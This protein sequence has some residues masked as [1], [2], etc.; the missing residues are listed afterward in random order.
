MF[1]RVLILVSLF[2]GG[3]FLV[4]NF[5]QLEKVAFA[6]R[7]G[8]WED[9]AVAVVFVV[10][11]LVNLA[12]VYRAIYR[13]LGVEENL[14]SLFI[15]ATASTFVNIVT[16]GGL[17]GGVALFVNQASVRGYSIAKATLA[18]LLFLVFDLIGFAAVLVIG[19]FVLVRRDDLT[20]AT[21]SASIILFFIAGLLIFLLVLGLQSAEKLGS[22]MGGIARLTNRIL[23]LFLKRDYLS[24]RDAV[25]KG[26]E[27]ALGLR[28]V[29]TRPGALFWPIV[30]ALNGKAIQIAI[31]WLIFFAFG[32][33]YSV[34][35]IVAG[36]SIA[37]LFMVV[38]PS[39]AGIGVVETLLPLTLRAMYV[40]LDA[41][42]VI[43]LTY[44]GLTFWLPL[45]LGMFSMRFI[46][47]AS[48]LSVPRRIYPESP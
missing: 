3:L 12:A 39:P 42:V 8:E 16:P 40:P 17:L 1:R 43:T 6:V 33:P 31:F 4:S 20:A 32:I 38:S 13:S 5:A 7:Q 28:E 22:A 45:L 10:L 11:W 18:G 24:E 15:I 46:G 47:L 25:E 30:L 29:R 21:I 27:A 23:R 34:G 26:R 36:F 9:I 35:T 48:R 2:L 41:A 19:L 44:R 14:L 37:F